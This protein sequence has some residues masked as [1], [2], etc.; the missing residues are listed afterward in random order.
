MDANDVS[1]KNQ[2]RMPTPP[3]YP[4][5]LGVSSKHPIG[6][7]IKALPI[8]ATIKAVHKWRKPPAIGAPLPMLED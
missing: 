1:R 3:N 7:S 6:E 8:G 5:P 2:K 4:P